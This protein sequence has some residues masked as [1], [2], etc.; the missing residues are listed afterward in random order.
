MPQATDL[1][2]VAEWTGTTVD[3]IQALNPELRRWTTPAKYPQY[4]MKVPT[5]TADKLNA[6]LSEA[7]PADFST[8]KWYS[9][10]KGETLLTVARK[11]GVSRADVA[12]AN[13]LTVKSRLRPGQELMIPRAP[14]TLLA[15]RTERAVPSAVASR[16]IAEPAET[17]ADTTPARVEHL[18][19]KVKR[20]D[21]LFSIA[22]LFDTTVAKIKSWNRLSSNR[23]NPGAKLKILASR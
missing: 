10:K 3:E 16:A 11:F 23:I 18:T 19:Y 20:G 1:R 14:A 6:K 12:E 21:T 7:S 4:E 8:F 9:A 15:A 17:A 2:R 5:G 22:Q 13:N